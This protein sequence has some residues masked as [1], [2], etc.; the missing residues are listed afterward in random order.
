MTC[1]F[2]K[3]FAT[4][5][6]TDVEN[7]FISEYLPISDGD[8]VKVYLYGLF[9]CKNPALDQS[10]SDISDSLKMSQEKV[11]DCFK[12]WEEFGLVSVLSEAPLSV[13]YVPVK[14]ASANKPTKYKAEKYSE[15]SKGLQ[16][17]LSARMIST[18]EFTEYYS[19]METYQIKPEAM[20]MIVKYCIDR[21]GNDIGYRYISKVAKDFGTRGI[22]T[23]EKVENELSSYVYRTAEI[24]RILKALSLTRQPEIEDL[25][26]LKVWTN[27]L[28]F[29]TENIIFAGKKIKK[30]SM[31]KLDEFIK[32]L[33]SRKYFSKE[34]IEVFFSQ[35]THNFELAIKINKELSVYMEVIDTVVDTYTNKWLSFGFT[36]EALLF[37]ASYLFKTG[38][39][40]LPD[41]DDLVTK[42]YSNGIVGLSAVYDYFENIKKENEFISKILT[43]AGI[44]RRPNDWDRNNLLKWKKEWGFNDEMIERAAT[45]ASGKSSPIQYMTGILSNWK[46]NE[47]YS[48]DAVEKVKSS[49]G[50][51]QEEYNREYQRRRNIAIARAQNNLDKALNSDEFSKIYTRLNSIER[52][53]AYAEIGNNTELLKTLE[54]E[55]EN[56]ISSETAILKTLGLTVSDLSPKYACELC[57]DTGYVGTKQCHCFDLEV[58]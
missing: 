52:D 3:E 27:E 32:E 11:L 44:N 45:L 28:G 23:V 43:V 40:T 7:S 13:S 14:Y 55:K 48:L 49:V 53:L 9:L 8:A 38:K 46:T 31:K 56:L 21:K 42:L 51:T 35:K 19:I 57:K 41:M 54:K 12:Y 10:L 1:S 36:D 37:I 24:E 33:Y 39:N 50:V 29:E 30:G 2:S 18:N 25:N 22:I 26:M 17:L 34:E 5:S 6:F 15:F 47:T 58:K 16:A 4:S 20:L